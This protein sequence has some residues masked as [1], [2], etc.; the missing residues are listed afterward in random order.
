MKLKGYDLYTNLYITPWEAALG[1]KVEVKSIDEE[2]KV[3]IPQGIQS[4]EII[5]IPGKG[6]RSGKGNRGNFIAEIK[7]MVPKKLTEQEKEIF[8]RLKKISKFNP[9]NP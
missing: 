8:E 7:I 6:Y 9:R 3:E 2:L 4:G 5:N 1:G